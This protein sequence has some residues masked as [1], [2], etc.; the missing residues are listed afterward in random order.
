CKKQK[1]EDVRFAKGIYHLLQRKNIVYEI[2]KIYFEE[3]FKHKTTEQL[4]H[5]KR[6]LMAVN[7]HIA[8]D[9]LIDNRRAA[10]WEHHN[11]FQ[12]R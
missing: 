6:I 3:I 12:W 5:I 7:I 2:L 4:E 10:K 11:R 8:A 9:S 1:N